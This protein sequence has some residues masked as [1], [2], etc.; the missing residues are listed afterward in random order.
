[1]LHL[2]KYN[3]QPDS[4]NNTFNRASTITYITMLN[5]MH[6]N[7]PLTK[8]RTR[9]FDSQIHHTNDDNKVEKCPPMNNKAQF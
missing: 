5:M 7:R 9:Q 6:R 2:S 1:M 8:K 4:E 3:N